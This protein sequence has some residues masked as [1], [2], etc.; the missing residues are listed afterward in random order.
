MGSVYKVLGVIGFMMGKSFVVGV[1]VVVVVIALLML[2]F[3]V[4]SPGKFERNLSLEEPEIP[5]RGVLV[6]MR[7]LEGDKEYVKKIKDSGANWVEIVL[8]VLVTEDGEMIPYDESVPGFEIVEGEMQYSMKEIRSRAPMIEEIMAARI[9]Q[10]HD[11][12]FKVFLCV[13]HERL[14][15]HH[16]YG[17]G[18]KIDVEDFLERA[19]KIAVRWGEIAEDN[20]VEMY[21]PRKELQ[22]FVGSRAFE[23]DDRILQE[24]R[25]VY[26]GNLVRGSFQIY[27]WS[28]TGGCVYQYEGMPPNLSGWDYLGVDFYGS[29]TDTF[30]D[31][32]AMYARFVSKVREIK[33]RDNFKGVIFEELGVPHT[34]TEGYWNDNSL[35]GEEILDRVYRINFEGGADVIEGFFPWWWQEEDR[36]LP[37]GRRERI[38]PD[39]IIKQYYTASTIAPYGGPTANECA[40]ANDTYE[41]TRIL[42]Q[43]NFEDD[44][45]WDLHSENVFVNNGV[46]EWKEQ[47]G[48]TLKDESSENWQNY[49]FGGDFMITDGEGFDFYVRSIGSSRYSFLVRPISQVTLSDSSGRVHF[50]EAEFFVEYNKWHNFTIVVKGNLLQFFIDNDKVLEY[51]DPNPLPKGSVGIRGY[52]R[53]FVDN[54]EMQE[55]R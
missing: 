27:H 11:L 5:V 19:E 18:M 17:K 47:E 40:S 52:G 39:K 22:M 51:F 15:A 31:L 7:A 16:E 26:H 33:T 42:L 48:I 55:I 3:P 32:A 38:A 29:D 12:G 13:Y 35:S 10:F 41:V 45:N 54:V 6:E 14:G 1:V 28:R 8:W 49:T 30:E 53:A 36:E 9:K 21:A 37:A 46:L 34:G 43:D 50:R 23:F 25:R 44:S 4:E 24:L 20:G 2:K